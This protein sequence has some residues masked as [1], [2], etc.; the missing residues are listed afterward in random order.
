MSDFRFGTV[1]GASD[2]TR[3]AGRP[4]PHGQGPPIRSA[5]NMTARGHSEHGPSLTG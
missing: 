3:S 1:P 2:C 5:P 4:P